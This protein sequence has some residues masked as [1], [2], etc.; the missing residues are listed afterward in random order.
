MENNVIDLHREVSINLL[1]SVSCHAVRTPRGQKDPGHLGWDPK[2]NDKERSLKTI[3][4]I[5]RGNDNLGV[6][7]FGSTIDIDLDTDNPQLAEALDHFLPYTPHT[8]G[9]GKRKRTHRLYELVHSPEHKGFDRGDYPFLKIV[10]KYPHLKVEVRGG[11]PKNG[12]YSLLPGSLHPSGDPYEWDDV[13]AAKTTPIAADLSKIMNAVRFAIAVAAIA[14]YWTEGSRNSLC[15]ALSGFLHRAVQHVEDMG[16]MSGL[17]FTKEDAEAILRG[18]MKVA[19]DDP[20]DEQMRIRTFETTW[21]KADNGHPTVGASTI[22]KVTGDDDILALLYTLLADT[23]SLVELD[24]FM[25]R[26]AVRQGTSN[27]IDLKYVGYKDISYLMSIH[28]FRNSNMHKV[29][30]AGTPKRAPMTNI[31]L[32]SPRAIRVKGFEFDP[33]KED[34]L[35][36]TENGLFVNQWRGYAI[37]PTDDPVSDEDVQPFI[38]YVRTILANNDPV[39]FNWIIGWLADMFQKPERK[40]GTAMVLVGQP[41]SGKSMLGEVFIRPIIG[42][43]H[44]MQ[45]NTVESVVG[46]FNSDSAHMLLIQC[47]EASNSRRKADALKLKSMITDASRRVE[48]KGVNA[49]QVRDVSR[50]MFTSNEQNDAIA[51][52]DGKHDRRY[53]VFETNNEYSYASKDHTQAEKIAYFGP[54]R[55]WAQDKENLAKLHKWFLMWEIDKALIRAPVEN[56]ARKSIQQHSQRGLDDWLMQLIT[57]EHPFENLR[58]TDQKAEESFILKDGEW[59]TNQ[60]E[61]PEMISYRRLEDS[62]NVYRRLRG[63]TS[64]SQSYNAQQIKTEFTRRG[65]LGADAQ[66]VRVRYKEEVW[67]NGEPVETERRLRITEF[68]S[69]DKIRTYLKEYLGFEVDDHSDEIT[70]KKERVEF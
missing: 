16:S 54:L 9:R 33:S 45:T 10:E 60:S 1:K 12:E 5:E 39:A 14:P 66:S 32:A 47:D 21:D 40:S 49:Y 20:S 64:T 48:P 23:P 37:P 22:T 51:I 65:L 58:R 52:V 13:S 63:M 62:Y 38:G 35:I 11:Q 18:V 24:E 46:Q 36:E 4:E 15:M 27:I 41:G 8:W 50:F 3:Y 25:A 19:D 31:L 17:F 34:T 55:K 2:T 69:R 30:G 6:H 70:M 61:W 53:G 42:Y 43:N 28:D 56:D 44:S 7:L 29:V 59:V 68:P 57:M 26:Y 67:Q